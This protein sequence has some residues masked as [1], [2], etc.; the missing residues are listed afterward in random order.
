LLRLI[1]AWAVPPLLLPLCCVLI[2][3]K[4][5]VTFT[6][7]HG[8]WKRLKCKR[9]VSVV[10]LPLYPKVNTLRY[11]YYLWLYSP[12]EP[13]SP[14]QFLNLY[15]VGRTPWTGDQPVARPLPAHRTTQTQHK[16]TQTS[17]PR[18][19]FE[20]TIPVFER[21]KTVHALGRRAATVIDPRCIIYYINSLVS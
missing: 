6:V 17:M 18:V 14:F 12:C 15:T 2:K 5:G 13:W 21:A 20:P 9:G 7:C 1:M 3:H 11:S 16:R 19:W 4:E 8:K 10:D